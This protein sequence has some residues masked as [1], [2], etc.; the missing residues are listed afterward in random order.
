MVG[1]GAAGL[2]AA[3]YLGRAGYTDVTV[4]ERSDRVGG[5]CDTID[6][7][8]VPVDLGAFTVTPAY[9]AVLALARELRVPTEV[10]P[11]RYAWDLRT[12][13]I[14]PVRT[15]LTRDF[16]MLAVGWASIR[17]LFTQWRLRDLLDPPGFRGVASSSD[18][19]DLCGPLVEWILDRGFMPLQDMFRMVLPDMGYG[20]FGEVP[21]IYLL[22]Y[23]NVGNFTTLARYGLGIEREW[24]KRFTNGFGSLWTAVADRLTVETEVDITAIRRNDDGVDITANGVTR[25]F[26]H[27]VLACPL[28]DIGSVL[29]CGP[30]ESAIFEK[31]LTR[32]Y[33]VVVARVDGIPAQIV[34]GVHHLEDGAPWEILQPRAGR[35]VAVFYFADPPEQDFLEMIR[36]TV[37]RV[38]PGA[39]VH[40][41]EHHARWV[42]FPHFGEEELRD[43]Y[44]DRLEALQGTRRTTYA[45]GLLAFETVETVVAYSEALVRRT[46]GPAS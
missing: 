43:G 26:D 27:L 21:T 23:L 40:D 17:Y 42:Y 29:D 5:K 14:L 9:R 22:K 38:Y 6:V 33:H 3:W 41:V 7:D 12:E 10:Q 16:G 24:P 36:R 8:G 30:E 25:G 32:D 44:F 4:L 15:V 46:F 45:G 28:Q 20:T 34:D 13:R 39:I 37:A 18:H 35:P 2:S 19:G 31:I 1:G 11:P